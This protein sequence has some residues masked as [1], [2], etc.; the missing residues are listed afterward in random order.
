[1]I[2]NFATL[3]GLNEA[4]VMHNLAV[5]FRRKP[6]WQGRVQVEFDKPYTRCN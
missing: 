4:S 3:K 5:I 6:R 1:M 2:G